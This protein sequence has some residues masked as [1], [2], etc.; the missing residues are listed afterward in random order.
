[1]L[2]LVSQHSVVLQKPVILVDKSIRNCTLGTQLST[3]RELELL[4][5]P[6]SPNCRAR[7]F[8]TGHPTL[9]GF[10]SHFTELHFRLHPCCSSQSLC[11][12][13]DESSLLLYFTILSLKA[14]L[15]RSEKKRHRETGPPARMPEE[16]LALSLPHSICKA[17]KPQ[18]C[19]VYWQRGLA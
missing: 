5:T 6:L 12:A 14:L 13:T 19:P 1:M 3:P 16:S 4:V 15:S 9:V 17:V 2:S 7:S 18:S 11:P 10:H 8:L